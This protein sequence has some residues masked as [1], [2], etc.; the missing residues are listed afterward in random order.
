MLLVYDSIFILS[1]SWKNKIISRGESHGIC[2]DTSTI[3][4]S[5]SC[6]CLVEAYLEVMVS[7]S[8]GFGFW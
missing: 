1:N 5:S 4:D 8:N 7:I 6:K 3:L 2:I